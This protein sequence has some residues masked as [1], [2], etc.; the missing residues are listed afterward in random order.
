MPSVVPFNYQTP[1]EAIA[2]WIKDVMALYPNRNTIVHVTYALSKKLKKFFK[3]ALTHD[4]ETK[5]EVLEKFKKQGGLLLACGM[6]EGVD[7]PD[8]LCSLNLIPV[9]PRPNTE[10]AI[11]KRRRTVAV[12]IR[13]YDIGVL[14]TIQQ[15]AGRSTRHETDKSVVVIGDQRFKRL[16]LRYIHELP[17]TF[18]ESVTW[19]DQTK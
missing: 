17:E 5:S 3:G 6:Q 9:L 8:E 19:R 2:I 14:K 18:K 10:D 11:Q 16:Y 1:P 15:M 7:L 4:K 13:D 12:G